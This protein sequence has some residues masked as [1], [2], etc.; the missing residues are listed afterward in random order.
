MRSLIVA[1]ILGGALS[2]TACLRSTQY[3]CTEDSQCGS[4]G[5]CEPSQFC[6]FADSAC[7]GG[8]RYGEFSGSVANQC[9]D[10]TNTEIDAGVD[11]PPGDGQNGGCP[12]DYVALAGVSNRQYR[13]LMNPAPWATHQTACAAHG[14]NTYLAVPDDQAELTAIIAAANVARVWVGI[15]DMATEGAYV[16]SNG[17]TFPA[18]SPLWGSGEPNNQALGGGA[19][20]NNAD[21]VVALMSSGRLADDRCTDSYRAVCEC[22]P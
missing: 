2:S 20:Q 18:N 12:A 15:N 3:R 5:V 6:S 10:E 22:E 13:V 17:G 7:A 11:G 19:G 9:V 21:C 16:T 14:S 1:A 8:R 4:G